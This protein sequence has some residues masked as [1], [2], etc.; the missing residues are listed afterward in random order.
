VCGHELAAHADGSRADANPRDQ[1][2]SDAGG[3]N[4][5]R[6][7]RGIVNAGFNRDAHNDAHDHADQHD[8]TDADGDADALANVRRESVRGNLAAGDL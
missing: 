2:E 8:H 4:A 7:T 1:R 3:H 6:R 5:N